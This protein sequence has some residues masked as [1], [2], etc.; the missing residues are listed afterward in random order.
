MARTDK[1]WRSEYAKEYYFANRAKMLANATRNSAKRYTTIEGRARALLISA[2]R[3]AKAIDVPFD[4]TLEFVLSRLTPMIC[5][6]TGLPLSLNKGEAVYK[7]GNPRAPSI[8]RINSRNGYTKNNTRIV[9][10]QANYALNSFGE[11]N[12]S[13]MAKAYIRRRN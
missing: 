12:F 8:D 3:R 11:T 2:R 5:E 6:F 9:C 4:L 10:L 7:H 13:E 1:A